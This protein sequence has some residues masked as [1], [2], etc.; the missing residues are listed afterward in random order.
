MKET[1]YYLLHNETLS[2]KLYNRVFKYIAKTS[3]ETIQRTFE[4]ISKTLIKQKH[5]CCLHAHKHTHREMNCKLH[6]TLAIPEQ[7]KILPTATKMVELKK[8]SVLQQ[9]INL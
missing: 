1:K 6:V 7:R 3:T 8:M 9:V 5:A 4:E 2:F